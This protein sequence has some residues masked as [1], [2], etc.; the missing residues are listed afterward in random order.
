MEDTYKTIL[1]SYA[2]RL[3]T[4]NSRTRTIYYSKNNKYII[5]IAR[6]MKMFDEKEISDFFDGGAEKELKLSYGA[7]S[8]SKTFELFD[9]YLNKEITEDL[10]LEEYPLISK[11]D[12][13][14]L[15]KERKDCYLELYNKY[16]RLKKKEFQQIIKVNDE[17][18]SI[19][20]QVGKDDLY[21]GY[22]Y[23][24][25][26]FNKDKVVRAPLL[27][28]KIKVIEKGENIIVFNEGVKVL[29][30]VFIM[31]Y[32][33]ENEITYK[34]SLDFEILEDDYMSIVDKIFKNIGIKY[35]NKLNDTDII[36]MPDLTKQEF[37][38]QYKYVDNN[39]EILNHITLGIFPISDKKIYD[40]VKDLKDSD[41]INE[42]LNSFYDSKSEIGVFDEKDE[43]VDE[44]KLKY[45][46]VLDYSQK[47]TLQDAID[48]N[49]IIQG[50]PGTGKSQVIVNIAANLLLSRK[51]ALFCSEKR[52]A[53]DVIYNRLG[54]LN[55]FALLLHDH[56]SE[57]NYFYDSIIKAINTTKENIDKYKNKS[58]NFNQDHKINYFFEF[59]KKY[60]EIISKDYRG[61]SFK[62]VLVN[63]NKNFLYEDEFKCLSKLSKNKDELIKFI[64]DYEASVEYQNAIKWENELKKEYYTNYNI[65]IYSDKLFKLR[66][67][68]KKIEVSN[69]YVKNFVIEKFLSGEEGNPSFIK[70]ILFKNQKLSD[71]SKDFLNNEIHNFIVFEKL[72]FSDEVSKQLFYLKFVRKLNNEQ[73]LDYYTVCISKEMYKEIDFDFISFYVSNYDKTMKEAFE[74]ME[75][76]IDDS[77][78]F[79]SRTC[80]ADI[81]EKLSISKYK[82]KVQKLL[83]EANK[84]R[85][86]PIKVII[87]KY[88][89]ILQI[90]FPLW[91][92]TP[93]VVSAVIP[94]KENIFSKVIFDEAS[95]L[96]IEKAVP[97]ISRSK[98]VVICGDSKQLRPTL[99]FE[100]R[101]DETEEDVIVE[102]EQESA[103][104]ENS[105]LDYATTSN[106]YNSSMLRYHYRCY[107][108]E[109][110]NF[111]NY[112][113]YN[114]NLVFASN[115][116]GNEKTPLETI[117]VNGKW[118]G[119]KNIV[120]ANRVVELVK[121]LLFNRKEN[122]TIGIVTLNV[123]QR[124]LIQELLEDECKK[125][126][127][128][129]VLYK[130]EKERKDE[131]TNEDESI[132]VKNLE[133][134]QGDERDIII[135]S[136]SYSK[137]DKGK[138]GSSLGEIQ[139][140]YG[141]NRL[142]VA[143]SRA[144]K[145]IYII[146]SFMGDDLSVNDTNKGPSYFK[147][148][149][150]YADA[151]NN[152]NIEL[153]KTLLESLAYEDN[154]SNNIINNLDF[155]E[156]IYN[157]LIK[158]IDLSKY[159]VKRSV[160][161]GSFV[162]NIA[163]YNKE[164]HKYLLG[165]ECNGM[166]TFA[167]ESEISDDVYRQ[168]YLENRGWN[169][170]KVWFSEWF[171]NK[172]NEVQNIITEL[173]KREMI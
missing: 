79:I 45:I 159:E 165:I 107:Y 21:I 138:I 49:C 34:D 92:M 35:V 50:P 96:F 100:S 53:T 109:L 133:S 106:K 162:I 143:I 103:L 86:P 129:S 84:K 30:P 167:N 44:F 42:M 56:I 33:V 74:N 24:Q 102:V 90:I 144:K 126:S 155:E 62:E 154:N 76:K 78:E 72:P 23:I 51:N 52:T 149:L 64:Y 27:L 7:V 127:E 87:D 169:I 163:I 141:E 55:S 41:S 70:K 110:I 117:N 111:S 134:V 170:Y 38:N 130:K 2:K 148:Y 166:K 17:N 63:N 113:F 161:I 94:L 136:I 105:L 104:T 9:K 98:S 12:L 16:E 173:S 128:F 77:I 59:V 1:D 37:K 6:F 69:N 156:E 40:D 19:I 158:G 91:I 43:D 152:G 122:Q 108:K 160:E 80:S 81:K 153:S 112:A 85:K 97:A 150:C 71:K 75:S 61:L 54:K 123:N 145:K 121:D 29:N 171:S 13:I 73:I 89:D 131:K 116:K 125:D 119:E 164:S 65:G 57:K 46:T 99:F 26:R 140:Q 95:Q 48:K 135:F 101:Y 168:Y 25:G 18:E 15:N 68:N 60:S 172:S 115:I 3:I 82:D 14:I 139:R 120:E 36:S 5:D 67:I 22:P 93:E 58:F 118:D 39:F 28:H 47:K 32:L 11:S 66:D 4:T 31:S 142:N 147:K 10:F 88:F 157:E 20:K 114:G 83:G 137:N 132:F 124:D 151:L 8:T 146:K